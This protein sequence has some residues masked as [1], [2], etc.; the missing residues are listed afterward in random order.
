MEGPTL[1][2]CH[3]LEEEATPRAALLLAQGHQCHAIAGV[4]PHIADHHH[5]AAGR[6]LVRRRGVVAVD[7]T[8]QGAL[9]AGVSAVHRPGPLHLL[10]GAAGPVGETEATRGLY[11]GR[12]RPGRDNRHR[13]E[14]V[15]PP[16]LGLLPAVAEL[17]RR[18][19]R[20]LLRDI[21]VN[22][23]ADMPIPCR[24]R[25][26]RRADGGQCPGHRLAGDVTN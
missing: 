10:A 18:P 19:V 13:E 12:S 26:L 24:R 2:Q 25:A 9:R 17:I 14:S 6:C 7:H 21:G 23:N 4:H 8:I 5:R 22:R 11:L 3:R 16:C 1:D 20:R 15:M